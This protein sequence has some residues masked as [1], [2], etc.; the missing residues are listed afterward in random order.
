MK[1]FVVCVALCALLAAG[2][3][4][5]PPAA[6]PPAPTAVPPTAV[7]PTPVPPTA[8]PPTVAAQPDLIKAADAFIASMNRRDVEAAIAMFTDDAEYRAGHVGVGKPQVRTVLDYLDGTLVKLI[9]TDCVQEG[10]QVTCSVWGRDDPMVINGVAGVR[11]KPYIYSFKDGKIQK[12]MGTAD[13]PEWAVHSAAG[14]EVIAW[15]VANRADEWK[16]ISDE[17]GALIRNGTTAPS[18]VKLY[19]EYGAE[20]AKQKPPAATDLVGQANAFMSALNR[21][22]VEAA[23][24]MFTDDAE[25]RAGHVGVGKA[26]VRTVIEYLDGTGL[27]LVWSECAQTG[28]EVSCNIFGRD[29]AMAVHGTPGVRFNPYTFSFKDG[30]IHKIMGTAAGP[31]WTANSASS[32]EATT[33][34]AANRADEWKKVTDEKGGLIRNAQTAPEIIRLLREW[35]KNKK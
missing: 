35:G 7:P 15:L 4:A 9:Q 22:D 10:A 20:L 24:A 5:P 26:Q 12:I 25:Y 16:K 8:A 19:R 2:C 17:K 3:T 6:Q 28:Q 30:K 29:D 18:L 14:K 32:K 33:W 23:M 1:S 31:E 34:L 11:F 13:G 27:R 21:R